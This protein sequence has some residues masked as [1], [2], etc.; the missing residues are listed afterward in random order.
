LV[1][2][3]H[4]PVRL[5]RN[6][7]RWMVQWEIDRT[8]VRSQ[9]HN[10]IKQGRRLVPLNGRFRLGS[11]NNQTAGIRRNG[12]ALHDERDCELPQGLRS[13]LGKQ[14]GRPRTNDPTKAQPDGCA[15]QGIGF[16][17][18]FAHRCLVQTDHSRSTRVLG[19]SAS[20]RPIFT[21]SAS[22]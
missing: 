10:S 11:P 20:P 2:T 6:Q 18:G 8:F 1:A 12:D 21:W 13:I 9:I 19:C 22:R 14:S 4:N 7:Q 3:K 5:N 15:R 17:S 16:S